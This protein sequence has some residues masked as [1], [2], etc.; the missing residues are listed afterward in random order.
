M[1]IFLFI[2]IT[3]A[4]AILTMPFLKKERFTL[5]AWSFVLIFSSVTTYNGV[6]SVCRDGWRSMSIGSRGACSHHGGVVAKL[7]DFGFAA[8]LISIAIVI[9][10][11]IVHSWRN[12]RNI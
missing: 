8:L 1:A 7:T 12:R 4:L 3:A 11:L 9:V 5:W 6:Y 10:F 2:S